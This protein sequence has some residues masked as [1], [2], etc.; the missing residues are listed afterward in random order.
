MNKVIITL[1]VFENSAFEENKREEVA[2]IIREIADKIEE[3]K[4]TIVPR[5]I[6]GNKIGLVEI[7]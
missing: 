2:R 1:D 5:D 7:Y 6:N 3:G 4:D